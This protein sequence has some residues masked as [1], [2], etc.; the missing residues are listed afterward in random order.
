MCNCV[1]VYHL[2]VV[3]KN[4]DHNSVYSR[5]VGGEELSLPKISDSPPKIVSDYY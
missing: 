5:T 3:G 4:R 2:F 1:C